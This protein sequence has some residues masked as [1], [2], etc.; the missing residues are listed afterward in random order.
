MQFYAGMQKYIE[1][2]SELARALARI[3][4]ARALLYT[5]TIAIILYMRNY[6]TQ[7]RFLFL[8]AS[9]SFIPSS[10]VLFSSL[11]S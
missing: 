3:S 10:L 7:V 8:Y 2:E 6:S 4:H 9:F 5:R 1:R 11:F